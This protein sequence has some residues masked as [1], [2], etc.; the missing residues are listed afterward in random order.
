MKT[1]RDQKVEASLKVKLYPADFDTLLRKVTGD[2]L[3]FEEMV[4]CFLG[5]LAGGNA[6]SGSDECALADRWYDRHAF[7]LGAG[8]SFLR[9]LANEFLSIDDLFMTIAMLEADMDLLMENGLGATDDA[10][11]EVNELKTR[12]ASS[13]MELATAYV[14]YANGVSN[15]ESF[16]NAMRGIWNYGWE[17][18][19]MLGNCDGD[20]PPISDH[21]NEFIS[22]KGDLV[23][24]L[25]RKDENGFD[26][27]F[28]CLFDADISGG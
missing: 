28:Q 25:M 3:T 2:G 27:V 21:L 10:D 5:D 16:M 13:F 26:S 23:I 8:R 9:Y 17:K 7:D 15:G 11:E 12:I 1:E 18:E 22:E 6:R 24:D 20:I 19:K 4:E 14:Q